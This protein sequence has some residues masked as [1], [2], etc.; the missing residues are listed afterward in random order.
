MVLE[1]LFVVVVVLE[2]V[3]VLLVAPALGSICDT[4]AV[5]E[6]VDALAGAED[7]KWEVA[8]TNESQ[9]ACSAR[10]SYM[11]MSETL[12]FYNCPNILRV[13]SDQCFQLES[14]E[15]DDEESVELLLED[16]LPPEGATSCLLASSIF[17]IRRTIILRK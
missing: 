5:A 10:G 15:L 17:R 6:S 8:V 7:W 3:F 14:V 16:M 9:F 4:A 13:Y 12:Y 11:V 1:L 2:V